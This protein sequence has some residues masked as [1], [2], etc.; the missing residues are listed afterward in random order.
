MRALVLAALAACGDNFIPDVGVQLAALPGVTVTEKATATAG[1]RYFV[2]EFTQP[3]DH[4]DPS[5]GTFHQQVSLLHKDTGAP[6]VVAT[7]GYWDY[8]VDNPAELTLML[9]A[10]QI[11]IEHRFFAGSTPNPT[12]WSKLTI[13]QMAADQHAIV[14]ALHAIYGGPAIATGASKGGMTAMYYRRFFPDD[15]VATVPYVAPESFAAP[16]SRYPPFLDTVG[17]DQYATCRQAIRDAATEMLANRRAAMES[18]AAADATEN[19]YSY[20]RIA[21]GPA[22]E[23]AIDQL[24]WSFWQ[25]RGVVFCGAIPPV[26]AT[27]DDLWGFLNDYSPPFLDDDAYTEAF[28]PYYFQAYYQLGYPD[29]G[30]SYLQPYLM[31]SDADYVGSFPTAEPV[32][33]GGAAMHDIDDFVENDGDHLLFIYGQWDPWTAG[34]FALGGA[35]DALQ[36][37]QAQGTHTSHIAALADSDRAAALARLAAW[38]GVTPIIP[39]QRESVPEPRVPSALVRAL[40]AR[41]ATR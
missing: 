37:I 29:P 1:Y 14:T 21:L 15:V 16:D 31:Y 39:A 10:N 17:G 13:A 36:L 38:T 25:Y 7:S 26:T 34:A 19:Y 9:G 18:R 28:A 40:R 2:L 5:A 3:V 4:D 30:A 22:V 35:K 8:I 27:D 20:T 11:S 33:D 6:L 24:E 32:F 41:R 12:D 23:A